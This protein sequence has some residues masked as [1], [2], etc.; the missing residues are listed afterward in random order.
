MSPGDKIHEWRRLLPSDCEQQAIL[1]SPMELRMPQ[2]TA[3]TSATTASEALPVVPAVRFP[4]RA[5]A[6]A[7]PSTSRLLARVPRAHPAPADI[8]ETAAPCRCRP[9]SSARRRDEIRGRPAA[10]RVIEENGARDANG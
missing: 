10:A 9:A 5:A 4:L 3:G 1:D 2:I 6:P 7:S 8:R